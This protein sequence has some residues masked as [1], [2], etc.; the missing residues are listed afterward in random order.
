MLTKSDS[1]S[2]PSP[3][4]TLYKGFTLA[5]V[6][7]TLAI[8]G[9]VAAMTIPTLVANYQ[10][11]VWNTSSQVFERKLEEA[12][13]TMNT[14]QTLAGHR[15]TAS[16]LSA[17]SKHFKINK[18]CDSDNL[19]ECIENNAYWS[20]KDLGAKVEITDLDL[21]SMKTAKA[22]GQSKWG[23][24][25]LGVQFANGVTALVAYNDL[26][27]KQDPY[28]NRITGTQC[29]SIIYDTSG[30]K[31]PN[32]TGKD[33]RGINSII[34]T[35]A[36]KVNGEC[37]SSSFNPSPLTR[38]EVNLIKDS[39]GIRGTCMRDVC[40]DDKDYWAG[41]AYQCGGVDNFPT[42]EEYA[43]IADYLFNTDKVSSGN[44]DSTG[45][46]R[47]YFY[48]LPGYDEEKAAEIGLNLP[49]GRTVYLWAAGAEDYYG[50]AHV[51]AVS[52][53]T[54]YRDNQADVVLSTSDSRS[55]SYVIGICRL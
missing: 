44:A 49:T 31:N 5:E 50:A 25:T 28:S 27:C 14:Q 11:R 39:L 42:D 12:L 1:D 9:I 32:T 19:S 13:K 16:F 3:K 2:R 26:D 54:T 48:N 22:L 24:E 41:A 8:I 30:F 20:V 53:F 52:F 38:N 7:I 33:L 37:F 21:T 45:F 35:C 34:N 55:A 10:S 36:F 6:L 43:Y 47:K 18:I 29:L 40:R 51:N 46:G 23:T 17:L 4:L 15:S